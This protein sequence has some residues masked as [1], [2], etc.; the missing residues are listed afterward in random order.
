MC[1]HM[2]TVQ[3]AGV[4]ILISS[5]FPQTEIAFVDFITNEKHDYCIDVT[6]QRIDV[7]RELLQHTYPNKKFKDN[8]I[9]INALY[10]D[11]PKILIKENVILFHGVLIS[12]EQKGYIFT[13]PSGSG[14]STHANLWTS[15]FGKKVNIINGDKP[16]I[17]LS[18]NGVYAYGSPWKGKE[19]IGSNDS[20]KLSA[21]C[22]LQRGCLNLIERVEFNTKSLTWLLEQSQIRGLESSVVDRVRWFKNATKHIS[23]YELECNMSYEAVKVAYCGMNR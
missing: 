5:V 1:V 20:V 22:Y 8:E 9:E 12:M 10:R 14:K 16:L 21:I 13:A 3:L 23:L 15:V 18:E 4:N 11:I 7:E 17:K 2:F 6:I 19:N